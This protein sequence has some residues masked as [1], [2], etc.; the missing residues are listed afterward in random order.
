MAPPI[1]DVHTASTDTRATQ[2]TQWSRWKSKSPMQFEVDQHSSARA[3]TSQLQITSLTFRLIEHP[4]Q[5]FAGPCR[6]RTR[7]LLFQRSSAQSNT[8][9]R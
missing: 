4:P 5:V 2:R 1:F 3:S 9:I 7:R 6:S 8:S